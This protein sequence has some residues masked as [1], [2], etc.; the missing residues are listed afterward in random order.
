M[1]TYIYMYIIIP[2]SRN[3]ARIHRTQ[4]KRRKSAGKISHKSAS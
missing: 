3:F 4:N 2:I 1:Y